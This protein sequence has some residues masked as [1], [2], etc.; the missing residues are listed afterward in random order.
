MTSLISSIFGGGDV[1][2]P[3][4]SDVP[5][6]FDSSLSVPSVLHTFAS[7]KKKNG[8]GGGDGKEEANAAPISSEG[9]DSGISNDEPSSS[10]TLEDEAPS[11][12][13]TTTPKKTVEQLKEEEER[14][15][16]VGNLPPDITRRSLAGIF[17][18]CGTVVSTRLRS[19]AVAGVKL[20]PEQAGNQ[21]RV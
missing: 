6:L 16:F 21:V 5:D 1:I 8:D 7:T 20:P 10:N 3:K 14:T 2:P 18:P 13:N 17:K 15:I 11:T 12:E 9:I 4:I 19:M